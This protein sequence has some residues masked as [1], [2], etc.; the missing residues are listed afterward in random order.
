MIHNVARHM[1]SMIDM[2][3]DAYVF[4]GAVKGFRAS[5]GRLQILAGA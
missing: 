4:V 5:A 2:L 3:L 1:D